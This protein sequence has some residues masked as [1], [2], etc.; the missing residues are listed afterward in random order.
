VSGT[1]YVV[2]TPIGNLEDITFRAVRVL[3]EV[4]IVAAEDTRTAQKLLA[5]F[6]IKAPRLVSLFE[7]NE[8]ARSEELVSEIGAGKSVALVSEAGTPGVSDP[9]ERLVAAA[10]AAGIRIEVLPGPVAAVT[11]LVGSGLPTRDFLVVG[12]LPREPGPRRQRLGVLRGQRSTLVFYESPERLGAC[13]SDMRDAFGD[14]RRVVVARELT[15]LHEEWARGTVAELAERYAD[16]RVR[17]E[18]TVVV[19][20]MSESDAGDIDIEA[21]LR[22]LLA[23]GL[24]PKDAAARLVVKTGKPRRQLY[25][26]ALSIGRER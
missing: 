5:H 23:S 24:G 14:Q 26:L 21:E 12:F 7:G 1:L 15:K 18:C 19:E 16:E 10:V 20:G 2:A 22:R 17:G 13:L 8:A 9:G 3:G 25:Q 11:A 4:D 6:E